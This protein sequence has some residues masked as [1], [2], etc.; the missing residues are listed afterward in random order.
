MQKII[1]QKQNEM[2]LYFSRNE[3]KRNDIFFGTETGNR[4]ETKKKTF[5]NAWLCSGLTKVAQRIAN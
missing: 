1:L 4:N 2:K 3:T 5:F